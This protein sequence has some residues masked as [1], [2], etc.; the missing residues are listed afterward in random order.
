MGTYHFLVTAGLMLYGVN[1]AD[2]FSFANILFFTIQIFGNIIFGILA[3][4][5]LPFLNRGK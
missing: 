5:M 2:G 4:V 1:G 3:M